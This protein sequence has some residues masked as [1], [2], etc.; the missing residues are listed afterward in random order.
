MK[1]IYEVEYSF[2]NPEIWQDYSEWLGDYPDT[3]AS[4]KWFVIDRAIGHDMQAVDPAGE[5]R[6]A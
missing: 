1:V 5:V 4:R 6:V 3:R 2:D